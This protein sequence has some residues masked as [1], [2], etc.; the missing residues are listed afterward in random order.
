MWV[1]SVMHSLSKA[2]DKVTILEHEMRIG[3]AQ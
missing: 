2:R 1:V 3:K